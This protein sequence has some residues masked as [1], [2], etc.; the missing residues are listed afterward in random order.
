MKLGQEW[1]RREEVASRYDKRFTHGGKVLNREEIEKLLELV[2][3][4]DK[5]V[6]DI[7]TGTGRFAE[8]M[9]ATGGEVTGLDASME[10]LKPGRADY[11]VGDALNLPFK[12]KSFD[13]STSMRFLHLLRPKQVPKFLK[14]VERVTSGK[15]VFESLNPMSLRATYQWY[16]PQ[17]SYLFRTSYLKKIIEDL[18]FVKNVEYDSHFLVPYGIY[19]V[20]PH[21]FAKRLNQA[22]K[23]TVD[24]LSPFA[25]TIYW[26]VR[27]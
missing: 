16:L 6:L 17:R 20:M 18:N 15:F 25:S 13:I 3:P 4:E 2:D 26:T 10:M 12:D 7:A 5:K 24:F 1:Y 27:F 14:E 21:G 23:K 8:A 19:Q 22:D 9:E 11:L